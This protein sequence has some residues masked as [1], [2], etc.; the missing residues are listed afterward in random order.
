MDKKQLNEEIE[1]IL[2]E[3]DLG[4]DEGKLPEKLQALVDGNYDGEEPLARIVMLDLD[5]L[6]V[7]QIVE[8][9]NTQEDRS[10][11][12]YPSGWDTELGEYPVKLAEALVKSNAK[13]SLTDIYNVFY[14]HEELPEA[15]VDVFKKDA[16][17][18]IDDTLDIMSDLADTEILIE[19]LDE[20][21]KNYPEFVEQLKAKAKEKDPEIFEEA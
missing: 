21:A 7:D 1:K 9:M 4:V 5:D 15:V 10:N 18:H 14:R 3:E 16:L 11:S 17:D 19:F 20:I 12:L 13:E 2:N 6:T 8:I